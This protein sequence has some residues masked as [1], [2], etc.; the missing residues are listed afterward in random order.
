LQE[1]I[2]LLSCYPSVDLI[3]IKMFLLDPRRRDGRLF[4]LRQDGVSPRAIS[5]FQC[6]PMLKHFNRHAL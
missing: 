5:F 2:F 4:C 1:L 6:A 3:V